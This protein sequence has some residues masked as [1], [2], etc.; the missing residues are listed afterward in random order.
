MDDLLILDC[1][2]SHDRLEELR[3]AFLNNG[4]K[5]LPRKCQLLIQNCKTWEIKKLQG[6]EKSVYKS[7]GE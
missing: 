6:K 5:I 4:L 7:T 1:K 2:K 3:N